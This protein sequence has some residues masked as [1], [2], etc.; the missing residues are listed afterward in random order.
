[1]SDLEYCKMLEV[2]INSCDVVIKPSK[3]KKRN[4]VD[5]VI[6]QVNSENQTGIEEPKKVKKLKLKHKK[7][8]WRYRRKCNG[9]K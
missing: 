4:V 3:R 9:K 6:E 2:P 5:E 1:M 7:R 8:A